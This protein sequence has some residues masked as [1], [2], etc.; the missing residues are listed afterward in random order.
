MGVLSGVQV[1]FSPEEQIMGIA[2]ALSAL[3]DHHRAHGGDVLTAVDRLR[4]HVGNHPEV[5]AVEA[6]VRNEL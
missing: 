3:V 6:Y 5:R 2:L 1:R 4:A